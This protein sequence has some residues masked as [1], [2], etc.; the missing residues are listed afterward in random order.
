MR[1]SLRRRRDLRRNMTDA[2]KAL[3]YQ[4]RDR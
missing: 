2:E 3:W 1:Q 4:L